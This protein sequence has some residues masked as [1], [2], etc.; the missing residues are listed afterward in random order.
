MQQADI[1]DAQELALAKEK[2]DMDVGDEEEAA[3]V[4]L[5]RDSVGHFEGAN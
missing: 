4:D 3:V 5:T 1:L 2:E